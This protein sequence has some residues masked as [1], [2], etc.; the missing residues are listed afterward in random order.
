MKKVAR[1]LANQGRWSYE[2]KDGQ[3]TA[4]IGQ[5]PRDANTAAHGTIT[6]LLR[7]HIVDSKRQL[8]HSRDGSIIRISR[9]G[10]DNLEAFQRW[11]VKHELIPGLA[12]KI[13]NPPE[14]PE[15]RT[16]HSHHYQPLPADASVALINRME[17]ESIET[18]PGSTEKQLRV[19][20]TTNP[21]TAFQAAYYLTHNGYMTQAAFNRLNA[22]IDHAEPGEEFRIVATEAPVKNHA[23]A[24][25]G[26]S[27]RFPDAGALDKPR[28]HR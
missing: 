18:P 27:T 5:F 22:D 14:N 26:F 17:W 8:E 7:S 13:Y 25:S 6:Y 2:E 4:F 3:I 16:T 15:S 24:A 23:T 12:Q 10:G 1:V 11:A 19:T 28:R 9:K 21:E 20:V